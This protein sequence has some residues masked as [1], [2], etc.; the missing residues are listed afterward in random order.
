MEIQDVD[1]SKIDLE[2]HDREFLLVQKGPIHNP[3]SPRF[4]G[5]ID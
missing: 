2:I 4:Q 1:I 3:N 5:I